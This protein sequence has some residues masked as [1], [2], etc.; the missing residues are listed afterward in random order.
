MK[1]HPGVSLKWW[2]S[3]HGAESL[4][5]VAKGYGDSF[6]FLSKALLKIIFMQDSEGCKWYI[7]TINSLCT[8]RTRKI[9]Q[10][11]HNI[12]VFN[13]SPLHKK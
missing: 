6:R 7:G 5:V 1:R 8:V 11:I 10:Y 4:Y 2:I 12:D 13:K 9:Y 3:A